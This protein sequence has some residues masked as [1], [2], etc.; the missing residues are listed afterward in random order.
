MLALN[1]NITTS[2]SIY[3]LTSKEMK[4]ISNPK[5]KA[6]YN[7][8]GFSKDNRYLYYITDADKEFQYLVQY[9]LSIGEKKTGVSKRTGT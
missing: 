3:N 1:Q 5:I 2:C 7:A 6:V 4:E 8:S 9:N